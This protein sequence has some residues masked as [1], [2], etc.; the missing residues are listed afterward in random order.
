MWADWFAKQGAMEHGASKFYDGFYKMKVQ[1][2]KKV[3]SVAAGPTVF[4]EVCVA[5]SGAGTPRAL[6]APCLGLPTAE[7]RNERAYLSNLRSRLKKPMLGRHPRTGDT[8]SWSASA[9]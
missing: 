2:Y 9:I 7:G 8:L 4:C 5:R 3:A 1:Y 6:Q